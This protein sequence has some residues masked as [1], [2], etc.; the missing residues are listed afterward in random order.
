M[1]ASVSSIWNIIRN[2]LTC[3]E[4]KKVKERDN[5][6]GKKYIEVSVYPMCVITFNPKRQN[7]HLHFTDEKT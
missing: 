3:H 6:A 4:I 2:F 7:N 5:G 1:A